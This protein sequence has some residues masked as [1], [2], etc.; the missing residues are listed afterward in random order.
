MDDFLGQL[1]AAASD[2][3]LYYVALLGALVIPD[4]C[5][6]L[7][8]QNGLASGLRYKRWFDTHVAPLHVNVRT[9]QPFLNG[10]SCYRFRCSFLHQGRTRRTGQGYTRIVFIEPGVQSPVHAHMNIL[11]DALNIDV[12]DFC[13]E[14][15]GS[16]RRWLAGVIGTEPYQTNMNNFVRRYPTGL[17]PY[18]AGVPVIS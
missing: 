15:V 9:H 2:S 13:L 7:E 3:R 14:M 1:E 12:Q 17:S 11:N 10:E 6:A 8:S 4:I 5:G 16:A 18:I